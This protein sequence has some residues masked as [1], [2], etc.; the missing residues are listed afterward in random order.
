MA[1]QFLKL[2]Q[3]RTAP[4]KMRGETV[5]QRMGCRPPAQPQPLARAL[6]RTAD[7]RGRQRPAPGTPEQRLAGNQGIGRLAGIILDRAAQFG[8]QRHD[9][10]LAPLAQHADRLAQGQ[11]IGGQRHRLADAQP[12]PVKEQQDRPVAGG[13]PRL[14]G[15]VGHVLAQCHD[16]RRGLGAWQTP[17]AAGAF[18]RWRFDARPVE[19]GPYRRQFPRGG[20][21]GQPF[22]AARGQKGAQVGRGHAGQRW[23][24]DRLAPMGRQETAE[25]FRRRDIGAHGMVGPAQ[26]DGQVAVIVGDQ[27]GHGAGFRRI[28]HRIEPSLRLVSKGILRGPERGLRLRSG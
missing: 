21:G 12:G 17:L 27:R 15:V 3:I 5:A 23:P 25:P 7:D 28:S 9:P 11:D 19:E 10:G 6:D 13:N 22:P 1:E 20:G 16:V 14:G 8:E 18:Q 2:P 24:V 4:Q 26:V